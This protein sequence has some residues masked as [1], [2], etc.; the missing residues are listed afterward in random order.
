M[1]DI[2]YSRE[3]KKLVEKRLDPASKRTWQENLLLKHNITPLVTFAPLEKKNRNDPYE[4]VQYGNTSFLGS[5]SYGKVFRAVYKGKEVAVKV[6]DDKAEVANWMTINSILETA[7]PDVVKHFPKIYAIIQDDEFT[8]NVLNIIVMELLKP[9]N[10]ALKEKLFGDEDLMEAGGIRA[11]A[12][13]SDRTRMRINR[14]KDDSVMAL[15]KDE[16]V[17]FEAFKH[18]IMVSEKA[19]NISIPGPVRQDLFKRILDFKPLSTSGEPVLDFII[20]VTSQFVQIIEALRP[21]EKEIYNSLPNNITGLGYQIAYEIIKY[22]RDTSKAGNF[23]WTASLPSSDRD[24]YKNI[25]EASSL[26][27]ALEYLES[28][29]ISWHDVHSGNVM[30][31]PSTGDPVIVDV[32]LYDQ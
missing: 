6:T 2:N 11:K 16:M 15:M 4:P 32:G 31:R 22:L 30:V 9:L 13:M 8:Y 1:P 5:G 23:P 27:K 20:Y 26:L 24:V 28:R 18:A 3:R 14:G 7:P 29:G 12:P 17:L 25:P 10:S 21:E 19:N